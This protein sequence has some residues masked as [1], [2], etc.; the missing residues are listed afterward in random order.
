MSSKKIHLKSVMQFWDD[1]CIQIIY[2]SLS[3][4]T[5]RRRDTQILYKCSVNCSSCSFLLADSCERTHDGSCS[6]TST[7]SLSLSLSLTHTQNNGNNN[8]CEGIPQQE[9]KTAP[10]PTWVQPSAM[11]LCLKPSDHHFNLRWPKKTG[12]LDFKEQRR[13]LYLC[14]CRLLVDGTVAVVELAEITDR[15]GV[16]VCPLLELPRAKRT[17]PQTVEKKMAPRDWIHSSLIFTVFLLR[18]RKRI[19]LMPQKKRDRWCNTKTGREGNGII[20]EIKNQSKFTEEGQKCETLFPPLK[21]TVLDQ[22]DEQQDL[23]T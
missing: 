12:R 17:F 4:W 8:K 18:C 2:G 5:W 14:A 3:C 21:A 19:L 1:I 6:G 10:I 16:L 11:M 20:L 23:F 13:L 15:L 22:T 7:L 9:P